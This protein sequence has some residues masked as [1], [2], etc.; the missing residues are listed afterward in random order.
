MN[1]P[2][3]KTTNT[4][5]TRNKLPDVSHASSAEV[6]RVHLP[7]KPPIFIT[8]NSHTKHA[9]KVNLYTIFV[10]DIIGRSALIALNQTVTVTFK[11]INIHSRTKV[12]NPIPN[13]SLFNV[14]EIAVVIVAGANYR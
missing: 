12:C 6:S 10:F 4:A 11:S 8:H 3:V 9:K 14:I 2:S 1:N 5:E 7:D 13:V